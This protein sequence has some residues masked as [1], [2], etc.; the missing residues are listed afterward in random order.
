MHTFAFP[1]FFQPHMEV[2]KLF[3][4]VYVPKVYDRCIIGASIPLDTLIESLLRH[5]ILTL[6]CIFICILQI[7]NHLYVCT[8]KENRAGGGREK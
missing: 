7:A 3:Q 8:Q 1:F 4:T 6:E 5:S 2:I